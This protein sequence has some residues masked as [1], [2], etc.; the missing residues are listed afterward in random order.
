M[1]N[2]DTTIAARINQVREQHSGVTDAV[3]SRLALLVTGQF[4]ERPFSATELA[5]IAKALIKEM[6]PG[7]AKAEGK[8]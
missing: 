6:F 1:S 8:Q 2:V 3:T 7:P 4:G 5:A